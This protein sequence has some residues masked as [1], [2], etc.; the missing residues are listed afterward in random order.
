MAKYRKQIEGWANANY[1]KSYGA[2]V[3]VECWDE[4]DYARYN[5]APNARAALAAAKELAGLLDEQNSN[6]QNW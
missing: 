6:A 5:E 4:D 2:S 3:I 1:E